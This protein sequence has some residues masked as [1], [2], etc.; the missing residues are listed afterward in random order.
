MKI[1]VELHEETVNK[2]KDNAMFA[3]DISSD[4]RWD[5]TSAIVNGIPLPKGHGRLIDADA[6]RESLNKHRYSDGFCVEHSIDYSINLEM[7]GIII[8]DAPTIIE[9]D[10]EGAEE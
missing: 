9:A 8:G 2:I 1:V 4:I 6:L 7:A 10:K 3:G 5:I